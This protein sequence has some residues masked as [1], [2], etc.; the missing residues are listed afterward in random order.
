MA[1]IIDLQRARKQLSAD[2]R[3][4]GHWPGETQRL[5]GS[6]RLQITCSCGWASYWAQEHELGDIYLEHLRLAQRRRSS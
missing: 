3:Q 1:D 5:A 2:A 4:T 6:K